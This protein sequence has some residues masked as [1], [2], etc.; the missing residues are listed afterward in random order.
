MGV[1]AEGPEAAR[2]FRDYA[3]EV[4]RLAA[5]GAQ[6]IVLPEKLGVA[7]DPDT[8]ETDTFFQSLADKTK[9]KIVVGLIHVSPPV[10]YNE[11]RVYAPG[12][13]LQSYDKHHMLPPLNPS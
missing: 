7:V 6:V 12:A 10:K 8:K 11:A 5:Q 9:S 13:T 4:E 1:A 3:V 2:L